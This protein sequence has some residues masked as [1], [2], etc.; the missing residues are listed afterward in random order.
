MR[1]ETSDDGVTSIEYVENR[2]HVVVHGHTAVAVSNDLAG[3]LMN[4]A[5]FQKEMS[6]RWKL[7][8]PIQ[9]GSGPR[10]TFYATMVF[11]DLAA[12]NVDGGEI[13]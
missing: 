9:Q 7:I 13:D 6:A 11:E 10:G 8:G 4:I 12:V 3:V 2:G 1:S 5:L